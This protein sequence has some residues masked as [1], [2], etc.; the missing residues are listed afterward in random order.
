MKKHLLA[1]VLLITCPIW[2]VP[3]GVIIILGWIFSLFRD[4]Y[5]IFYSLSDNWLQGKK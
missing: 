5:N 2:M 1:T 4:L 3:F